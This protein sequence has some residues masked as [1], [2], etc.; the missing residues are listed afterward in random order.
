[1]E[2]FIAGD[3]GT[4]PKGSDFFNGTKNLS[5]KTSEYIISEYSKSETETKAD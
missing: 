3:S 4:M 5:Q 1:L 2:R